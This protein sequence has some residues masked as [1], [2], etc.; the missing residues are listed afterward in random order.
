MNDTALAT[1]AA[2]AAVRIGRE[3]VDNQPQ[4]VKAA[5]QKVLEVTKNADLLRQAREILDR[6]DQRLKSSQPKQ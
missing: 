2:N 5:M 1:E 4:A 3:I 6:A